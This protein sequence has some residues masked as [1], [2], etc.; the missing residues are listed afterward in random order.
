LGLPLIE[1][2]AGGVDKGGRRS[3]LGLGEVV[4][5]VLCIDRDKEDK[6]ELREI[7]VADPEAAALAAL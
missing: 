3:L 2:L 6:A 7:H 1:A 5:L 4:L